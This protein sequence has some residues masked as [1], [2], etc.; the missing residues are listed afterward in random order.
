MSAASSVGAA[1]SVGTA[2]PGSTFVSDCF[3]M[4]PDVPIEA[5]RSRIKAE[6]KKT[7]APAIELKTPTAWCNNLILNILY[8]GQVVTFT[9]FGG[10][11]AGQNMVTVKRTTPPFT[12]DEMREFALFVGD[13]FTGGTKDPRPFTVTSCTNPRQSNSVV[14]PPILFTS[15]LLE[16]ALLD[17]IEYSLTS[18]ATNIPTKT[19]KFKDTTTNA[20]F[21]IRRNAVQIFC[22]QDNTVFNNMMKLVKAAYEST[23]RPVHALPEQYLIADLVKDALRNNEAF[24]V[25]PGP[26]EEGVSYDIHYTVT[27]EEHSW[28]TRV[29]YLLDERG[30]RAWGDDNGE[31]WDIIKQRVETY[32]AT[33]PAIC[34]KIAQTCWEAWLTS[35]PLPLPPPP[36]EAMVPLMPQPPPPRDAMELR[37]QSPQIVDDVTGKWRKKELTQERKA[38]S[39]PY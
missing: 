3:I 11:K 28:P 10:K 31:I 35:V 9:M 39:N 37:K 17:R 6:T 24:T 14:T 1:P 26:P 12:P 19:V 15:G 22:D 30:R 36:Q 23:A 34:A 4:R 8:H 2:P 13:F 32:C 25:V 18:H 7:T 21:M 20:T 38:A 16:S 27:P 29:S 5:V 33:L